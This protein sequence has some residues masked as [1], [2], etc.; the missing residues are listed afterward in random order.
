MSQNGL[1]ST[2][3]G[4]QTLSLLLENLHTLQEQLIALELACA[5]HAEYEMIPDAAELDLVLELIVAKAF[6]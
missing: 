6:S 5:L 3:L 1:Q 4:Q 2:K